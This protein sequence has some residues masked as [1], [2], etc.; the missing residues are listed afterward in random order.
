MKV[1]IIEGVFWTHDGKYSV[2]EIAD[3]S[4]G[5]GEMLIKNGNAVAVNPFTGKE[6]TEKK[7]APDEHQK[8][9]GE[10][11]TDDA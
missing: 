6:K 3:V 4:K 9:G 11:P 7:A 1:R 8:S 2:G 10:R 5:D